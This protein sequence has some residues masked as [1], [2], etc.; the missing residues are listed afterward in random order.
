MIRHPLCLAVTAA[1]LCTGALPASAQS[2]Q[3]RL[4]RGAIQC[5]SD[6]LGNYANSRIYDFTVIRPADC[7]TPPEIEGTEV[8]NEFVA[9]PDADPNVQ[10][11]LL[12]LPD[13][14][15]NCLTQLA[16]QTTAF[17]D[18]DLLAVDLQSCTFS[19]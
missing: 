11:E 16:G 3:F 5:I 19:R 18:D 2:L 6:H 7:P 17:G 15:L 1:I 8:G 12:L 14:A 13:S 10:P 9:I 4:T